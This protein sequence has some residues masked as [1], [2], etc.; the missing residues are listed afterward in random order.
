MNTLKKDIFITIM[1]NTILKYYNNSFI[2]KYK[3]KY[4]IKYY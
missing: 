2:K 1:D 3:R 4:T